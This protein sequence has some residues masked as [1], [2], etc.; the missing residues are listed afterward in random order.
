MQVSLLMNA[1]KQIA[2]LRRMTVANGCTKAE[3]DTAALKLKSLLARENDLSPADKL[4]FEEILKRYSQRV[5][6]FKRELATIEEEMSRLLGRYPQRRIERKRLQ[7][8]LSRIEQM[9]KQMLSEDSWQE[10][11]TKPD[12]TCAHYKYEQRWKRWK[13]EEFAKLHLDWMALDTAER[14]VIERQEKADRDSRKSSR[15]SA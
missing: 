3:A 5:E 9:M 1:N 8:E 7:E 14:R 4:R 6:A 11:I 10:S 15:H 12:K 13:Q 2:A